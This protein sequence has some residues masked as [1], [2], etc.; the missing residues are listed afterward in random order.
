MLTKCMA[1]GSC[2]TGVL[3]RPIS[4]G[5]HS[6]MAGLGDCLTNISR[7]IRKIQEFVL[8]NRKDEDN[9][10]RLLYV[11]IGQNILEYWTVDS[12]IVSCLPTDIPV[13]ALHNMSAISVIP[14]SS[15]S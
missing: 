14:P 3:Y 6:V 4:Y 5:I 1:D 2:P 11:V 15:P 12:T 9:Y 10:A 8:V 7:C 13:P